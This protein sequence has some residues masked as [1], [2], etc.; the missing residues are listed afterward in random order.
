MHMST[1]TYDTI[2]YYNMKFSEGRDTRADVRGRFAGR[3][4]TG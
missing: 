4:L 2:S 3:R 1:Y